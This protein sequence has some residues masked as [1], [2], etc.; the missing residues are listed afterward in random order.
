MLPTPAEVDGADVAAIAAVA[1][2]GVDAVVRPQAHGG[3]IV[4]RFRNVV[5][6]RDA[7]GDEAIV[8]LRG[9]GRAA[10]CWRRRSRRR[11]AGCRHRRSP[12]RRRLGHRAVRSAHSKCEA[13]PFRRARGRRGRNCRPRPR[14][15]PAP[16]PATRRAGGVHRLRRTRSICPLASRRAAATPARRRRRRHAAAKS[17]Q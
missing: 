8:G 10:R 5:I 6:A 12:H 1:E 3:E 16:R 4:A 7:G 17:P 2:A 14:R 15:A 9:E 13:E 11:C